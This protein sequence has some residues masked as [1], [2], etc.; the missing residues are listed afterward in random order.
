MALTLENKKAIVSEVSKVAA[1]ASF[2]ILANYRGLSVSAMTELRSKARQADLYLKV[3]PNTLARRAVKETSFVC[4]QP[5]LVGPLVVIFSSKDPGEAARL[6]RD[7]AKDNKLLEVKALS[8]GSTLLAANELEAVA[9][10]PSHDQAIALFMS[11]LKA[12]ISQLARTLAEPYAQLARVLG[13]V[14]DK[15]ASRLST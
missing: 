3:V 7:F 5:A 9:N 12:P 14:S 15:I 1:D 2:V 8:F 13:S 10:L 4:L 11:V 6:V